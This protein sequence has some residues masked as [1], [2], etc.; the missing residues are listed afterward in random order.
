MQVHDYLFIGILKLRS[1]GVAMVVCVRGILFRNFV[2]L[3]SWISIV[4]TMY[5]SPNLHVD[6][7][8]CKKGVSTKE[9]EQSR[10]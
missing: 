2:H 7:G 9:K 4:S 3:F 10:R 5:R 1:E 6:T 8:C